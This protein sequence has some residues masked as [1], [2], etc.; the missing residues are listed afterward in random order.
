MVLNQRVEAEE[1]FLAAA[2]WAACAAEPADLE[3]RD[4]YGGLDLS[5]TADL[6]ALAHF[7]HEGSFLRLAS[8]A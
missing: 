5:E 8:V 1:P 3:G 4:V 2:H 6:T 7:I